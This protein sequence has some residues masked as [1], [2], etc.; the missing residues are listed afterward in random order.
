[1]NPYPK[2]KVIF[3][4]FTAIGGSERITIDIAQSLDKSKFDISYVVIGP[5]PGSVKSFLSKDIPVTFI[6]ILNIWCFTTVKILKYLN[7]ERPDIVFSSVMSLNIR[8]ILAA[9]LY[10]KAKIIVRNDSMLSYYSK[11]VLIPARYSYPKADLIIS[12]TEEMQNDLIGF[13]PECKNRIITI[14]NPI[15][16]SKIDGMTSNT[17]SPFKGNGEINIIS[18]A[19]V[20]QNKGQDLLIKA[21]AKLNAIIPETELYFIGIYNERDLFFQ[22]LLSIIKEFSIENSVHF[23]GVQQNPYKWMKHCDCFVLSSRIEGMPNVV[24]EAMYCGVPVV[25]TDCVPIVNRIVDNGHNGY[26]TPVGDIDALANAI[27]KALELKNFHMTFEPSTIS[28]FTVLF[29]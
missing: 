17:I 4:L 5:T 1:M 25:C 8:V 20:N 16:F 18:V 26:V 29:E 7:K 14:H 6:H 24:L 2:K 11:R 23:V 27:C 12:Q 22:Q 3:F 9:K 13:I 28:A 21:F 19:S 15:N 10:G